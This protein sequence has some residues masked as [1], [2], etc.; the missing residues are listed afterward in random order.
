MC[1]SIPLYLKCHP[2]LLYPSSIPSAI[3]PLPSSLCLRGGDA[4]PAPQLLHPPLR[5][6]Q[7]SSGP[8]VSPP[9]DVREGLLRFLCVCSHGPPPR[10]LPGW[11]SCP[12]LGA[13]G[14]LVSKH[15]CFCGVA[16]PLCSSSPSASSF[17]LV[18][19][20]SLMVGCDHPSYTGQVPAE[21]PW[22]QPHRVPVT[23]SNFQQQQCLALMS[24]N[25]MDP[26]VGRS[27]DGPSFSPC[28]IVCVYLSLE[29]EHF[30][31]KT[32]SEDSDSFLI[33]IQ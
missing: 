28:F 10:A 21:P 11:W 24:V 3:C 16:V 23:N 14:G 30:W 5:A 7:T 12:S 13:L 20:L 17:I 25:R 8:R 9:T 22:K 33:Y 1:Y 32:L 29:Q 19:C 15:C 31:V 2:L 27:P 4:T 18:S 6:H 26:R